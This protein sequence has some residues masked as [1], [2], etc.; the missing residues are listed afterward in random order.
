MW[1]FKEEIA[2]KFVVSQTVAASKIFQRALSGAAIEDLGTPKPK[3]EFQ[4]FYYD[5]VVYEVLENQ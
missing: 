1:L 3:T 4:K 2:F 5:A